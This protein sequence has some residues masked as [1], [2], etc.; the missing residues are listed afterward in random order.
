[1]IE[2]THLAIL[3]DK[4]SNDTGK[5]AWQSSTASPLSDIGPHILLENDESLYEICLPDEFS[6]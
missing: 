6:H 3:D 4:F 5:R 1:M 2:T